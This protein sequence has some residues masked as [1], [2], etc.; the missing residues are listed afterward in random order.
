MKKFILTVAML[1]T[2]VFMAWAEDKNAA[3]GAAAAPYWSYTGPQGAVKWGD[4]Q[5][6]Y[7]TCNLGTKQSP[8]DIKGTKKGDLPAITFNYAQTAVEVVNNGQLAAFKKLYPM[9][10]RP[11]QP[12]N[13]RS[14]QESS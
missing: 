4:L 13:G 9:N 3:H 14:L 7:A 8:I 6:D 10:A 12:I 2:A 5:K 11:V 1:A